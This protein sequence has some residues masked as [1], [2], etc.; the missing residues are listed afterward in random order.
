MLKIP[1]RISREY[2]QKHPEI[3]FIYSSDFYGQ[4]NMGQA[5]FAK[6]EPNAFPIPVKK[7]MCRAASD[8]VFTDAMFEYFTKS[9]IDKALAAVP[10]DGRPIVCFPNI[11]KGCAD[12]SHNAPLTLAYIERRLAEIVCEYEIDY[13]YANA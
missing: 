2:I 1:A 5:A 13:Q 9:S 10:K 3:I 8:N 12:L 7:R 11:G 6:G 4:S